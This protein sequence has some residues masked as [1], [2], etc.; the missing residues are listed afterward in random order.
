MLNQDGLYMIQIKADGSDIYLGGANLSK[1]P[2]EGKST[3]STKLQ[4]V[5]GKVI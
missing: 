2:N 4:K 5:L 1:V 3:S